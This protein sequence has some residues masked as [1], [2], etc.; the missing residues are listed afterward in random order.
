M[1]VT[2]ESVNLNFTPED[3]NEVYQFLD[4]SIV[5]KYLNLIR[6]AE[7]EALKDSSS[8][9][10]TLTK[11]RNFLDKTIQNT[12]KICFNSFGEIYESLN[13]L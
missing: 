3:I 12:N 13:K 9:E 2:K 4:N 1:G 10:V 8:A 11:A 5:C 7:G 6:D